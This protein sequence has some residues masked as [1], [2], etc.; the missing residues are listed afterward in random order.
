MLDGR[1]ESED[2]RI[3]GEGIQRKRRETNQR[4]IR[5]QGLALHD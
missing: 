4:L 1:A 5:L 2:G 3:G